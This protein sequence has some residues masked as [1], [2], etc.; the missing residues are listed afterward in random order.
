[1]PGMRKCSRSAETFFHVELIQP[2]DAIDFLI[3]RG[4]A[5]RIDQSGKREVFGHKEHFVNRFPRP[6][7]VAQLFHG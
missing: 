3:S 2:D 4:V 1:M 6:I 7:A 5:D